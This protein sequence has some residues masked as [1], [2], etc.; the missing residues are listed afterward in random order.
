MQACSQ[1]GHPSWQINQLKEEVPRKISTHA[2]ES[3]CS[4]SPRMK[5]TPLGGSSSPSKRTRVAGA[6]QET[7]VETGDPQ[8]TT[9]E[10]TE[11]MTTTVEVALNHAIGKR[12]TNL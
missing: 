11:G 7:E 12:M 8:H 3:K 6:N 2:G 9:T 1:E 5:K 4:K 10:D